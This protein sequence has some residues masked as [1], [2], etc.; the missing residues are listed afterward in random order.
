MRVCMPKRDSEERIKDFEEVN[1]GYSLGEAV[2]EAS[3]CEQCEEPACIQ[4]CPIGV[5]IPEFIRCIRNKDIKRAA[6]IIKETNHLPGICGR[7]CPQ[8]RLC[9]GSCKKA[10]EGAAISIGNL[11][12][13]ASD[14]EDNIFIMPEKIPKRNKAKKPK[15]KNLKIA[16]VG[17]GPSGLTCASDLV[18][19][20][21][22]VDVYE[23]L[24]D[25]GGVLRY[26]IPEF[27]LPKRILDEEID[28]I[29][30]QGVKFH[31]NHIIG[32]TLTVDDLQKGYDAVF[33]GTGAG[34][35]NMPK[36]SGEHLNGVVT[37]NEYLT[38][39]N[40]MKAYQDRSDTPIK[41]P[42]KVV[43]VGGGNA[44]IDCARTAKRLGSEVTLV[45]RRSHEDMRARDEEFDNLNEEGIN[46]FFLTN[47]TRIIGKKR[48]EGVELIQMMI[49]PDHAGEKRIVPIEN[50]EFRMEC[51][52]IIFAI[53]QE[54]NPLIT[55]TTKIAH[56][57]DKSIVV[58][59]RLRTSKKMVFAGGDVVGGDT[60][61]IKAMRDGRIA[62][63]QIDEI[64]S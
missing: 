54:A 20:G 33:I 38:R 52:Q 22:D 63:I 7:V 36:I 30:K 37:A 16:V 49:E 18:V 25:I 41:R 26:G 43:V 60:I 39:I 15:K 45:Y 58:D 19:K 64:L 42:K 6:E 57:F 50:T 4:G 62:A 12:R 51:D 61:V 35:P 34:L 17:S 40:F 46:S 32:K 48:V 14:N 31:V 55:C 10:S 59:K 56:R 8:E 21:Y 5:N 13:F 44:A 29:K 28:K 23:A 27:R 9:E 11:E 47:P 53:G 3:R 2:K 24:H 1:I